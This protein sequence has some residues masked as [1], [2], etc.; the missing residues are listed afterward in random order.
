ME[1]KDILEE[2]KANLTGDPKK[3]GPYLK[4]QSEKYKSTEFSDRL[5]REFS[6]IILN[7][8]EKN[9]KD[10]LY[11]FLDQ[12]NDKVNEQLTNVEKRYNNLNYN[13]GIKILE[14]IIKNNILAWND[15]DK[16]TYKCFGTPL[17]YL[18]YKNLLEDKNNQKEIKPVNCNL[19]KVYW[20]YGLGLTKKER[21]DEA[22]NAMERAKELNPADPELYVHYSE[23]AK[24]ADNIES[25]KMCCDMLLKC[26]VTKD[27]VGTAYFNYSFYYSETG[28]FD[29]ALALLQMSHIFKESELYASELEFITK[30]MG[31]SRLPQMYNT[32]QL[33]DILLSENIQPGPSAAVVYIANSIAKE[34]EQQLELKYAKYFYDIV[35]E[36]T[37]DQ[38]TLKHIQELS[39]NIKD[40]KNFS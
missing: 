6:E 33:M 30:S 15:T 13:G 31:L 24:A 16:A 10:E 18:L 14:E 19:A 23:L 32:N 37:E 11:S 36:L 38:Q 22:F 25:L 3:D 8:T 5:E 34:F 12:E 21:Y 28:Q 1:Y 17:E 20:M 2:I 39:K 35:Y 40:M 27:Q 26:G 4:E 9:Y 29:K 7:I